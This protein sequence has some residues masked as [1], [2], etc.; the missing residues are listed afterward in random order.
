MLARKS[1]LV[2]GK[3]GSME[4]SSDESGFVM[5]P[6]ISIG[7]MDKRLSI[8]SKFAKFSVPFELFQFGRGSTSGSFAV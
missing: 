2:F 6:F 1:V 4:Q 3:I 7:D 8:L 5:I